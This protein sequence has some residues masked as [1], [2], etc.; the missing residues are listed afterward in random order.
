M[1]QDPAGVKALLEQLRSSEAWQTIAST[2]TPEAP[3]SSSLPVDVFRTHNTTRLEVTAEATEGTQ[4]QE[5]PSAATV[6]SLLY[7]LQAASQLQ[8]IKQPPCVAKPVSPQTGLQPVI[9]SSFPP[10]AVPSRDLRSCTFQQALPHIALLSQDNH[11]V[12]ALHNVSL[13]N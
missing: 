2:A 1:K 3:S 11:V 7:Q 13:F 5:S 4:E 12:E 9:D 6:T 10:Q 8:A